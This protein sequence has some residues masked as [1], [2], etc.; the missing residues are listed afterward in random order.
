MW[1]SLSIA[2]ISDFNIQFY[3][4]AIFSVNRMDLNLLNVETDL[5]VTVS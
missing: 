2:I 5:Q 3:Q 4:P 1:L